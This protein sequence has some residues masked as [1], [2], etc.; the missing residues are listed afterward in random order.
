[1]KPILLAENGFFAF[2]GT[3]HPGTAEKKPVIPGFF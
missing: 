3:E 1:M 2:W